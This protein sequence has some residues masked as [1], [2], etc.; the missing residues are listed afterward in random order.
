MLMSNRYGQV[1]RPESSGDG[2]SQWFPVASF[3]TDAGVQVEVSAW[4]KPANMSDA[5]QI[6][7]TYDD[8]TTVILLGAVRKLGKDDLEVGFARLF[9]GVRGL[10][11]ADARFGEAGPV[12][13]DVLYP[14]YADE[15][16]MNAR[17]R[18]LAEWRQLGRAASGY[19]DP[20]DE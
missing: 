6:V 11:L 2:S 20:E 9:E 15:N 17:E 12:H 8:T 4:D 16:G 13:A 3:L 10:N 18:M 5:T 7:L 19:I 1:S 14:L